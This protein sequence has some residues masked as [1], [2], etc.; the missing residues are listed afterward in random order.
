MS[1]SAGDWLAVHRAVFDHPKTK[2][3]AK[4]LGI[5]VAAAA[6]YL[7]CLWTWAMTVAPEGDLSR[8]DP[9][10]IEAA[11]GWGGPEGS[12]FQAATEC[13]WLDE[14]KSIHDW[15]DWRGPLVNKRAKDAQRK[16]IERMS[17]SCPSD[18]SASSIGRPADVPVKTDKTDRL[19]SV[20]AEDEF[21][22]VF[23]PLWPT[24]GNK[25][26]AHERFLATAL[27]DRPRVLAAAERYAAAVPRL[28]FTVRAENFIGGRKC[29]YEEWADAPPPPDSPWF[30]RN[31]NGGKPKRMMYQDIGTKGKP[32]RYCDDDS[33]VPS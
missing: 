15:C 4:K 16:R 31:G 22:T 8:Y 5:D 26:T 29:Y 18:A 11:A 21:S 19:K 32:W 20:V 30:S 33:L 25:K 6:G 2:R 17:T 23:W 10:D 14:D 12:F 27:H 9:E 1:G 3:L 24:G 28:N 7:I 13:R